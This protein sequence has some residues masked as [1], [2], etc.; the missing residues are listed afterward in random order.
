MYINLPLCVTNFFKCGMKLDKFQ[1]FYY[2]VLKEVAIGNFIKTNNYYELFEQILNLLHDYRKE[3]NYIT[4]T[5]YCSSRTRVEA[6][7]L[8][9]PLLNNYLLSKYSCN[10]VIKDEKKSAL[11]AGFG[12]DLEQKIQ[13]FVRTDQE[14]ESSNIIHNL[15]I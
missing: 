12:F 1:I 14:I 5:N 8:F 15:G 10:P 11:L 2:T 6:V 4:F 7:K 3:V 9:R 13:I